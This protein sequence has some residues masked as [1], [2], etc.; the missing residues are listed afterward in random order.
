MRIGILVIMI[1][2]I[3]RHNEPFFSTSGLMDTISW[4]YWGY[5]VKNLKAIPWLFLIIICFALIYLRLGLCKSHIDN[6]PKYLVF[7]EAIY[8]SAFILTNKSSNDINELGLILRF[9]VWTERLIF[10]IF[11]FGMLTKFLMN[12]LNSYFQPPW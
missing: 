12:E 8:F 10:G 5:G 3:K 2:E 1:I 11:F 7:Y 4:L 6:S 9:A